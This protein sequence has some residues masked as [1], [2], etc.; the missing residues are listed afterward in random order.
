MINCLN[1]TKGKN[2]HCLDSRQSLLDKY[3]H[4][5]TTDLFF[6]Y[7]PKVAFFNDAFDKF[8]FITSASGTEMMMPLWLRTFGKLG[9]VPYNFK[10][11]V[12]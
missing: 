11:V 12:G 2:C 8:L 4:I 10:I 3:C 1:R 9:N 7:Y 5:L 6:H